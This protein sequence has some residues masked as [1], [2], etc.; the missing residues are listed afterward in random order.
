M[1][2]DRVHF[3]RLPR[4]LMRPTRFETTTTASNHFLLWLWDRS[5]EGMLPKA[6][7]GSE[8]SLNFMQTHRIQRFYKVESETYV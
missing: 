6:L 1:A 5:I 8:D 3:N 4:G 7:T 2:G